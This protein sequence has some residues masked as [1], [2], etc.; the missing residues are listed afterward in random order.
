MSGTVLAQAIT[1]GLSFALARLYAPAEFGHYSIFV[2]LAGMLGA[3]STGA[4][5]RVILMVPSEVEARRTATTVLSSAVCLA[6]IVSLIGA[7]LAGV[8]ATDVLPLT[9]VDLT[10]LIPVFMVCF[11]G[12]QVFNYSSLRT[13]R[14][15][16]LAALKV[17]QSLTMGAMQVLA[18]G[19]K[20]VP[21]LILGNIAGWAILLASGL[22]WRFSL[23]H[24]RQ[25]LTYRSMA[26]VVRRHWRYPRYVMPNEALDRLS[27]QVPLLFIG[28]FLSLAA[29]GHYGFALMILSGPAALMGQAVGQAFLQFM[30]RHDNNALSL[31][32]A[33]RRIWAGMALVGALPFGAVL[34]FGGEIF[35]TGFGEEWTG[36]GTIAQLL[37]VLLFVRFVS[38]PTSTLYWKLNLQREQWY[39]S[40]AAASYRTGAYG[41]LAFGFSLREV[42]FLHVGIETVA[43][44]TYN[45]VAVRELW[46]RQREQHVVIA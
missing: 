10:V 46:R 23:G 6:A 28:T 32:L 19:A 33:T 9:A 29:A 27:N 31:D 5:D 34:L 2:G 37:A 35:G 26:A 41:L 18:S 16:R 15:R 21:G 17:C 38:S 30:G 4:L 24:F 36:A 43:I 12:A 14:V 1:L 3:V 22:R 39:F 8:G 11:A 13:G 7:V 25:D 40:V 45:L 20:S 42:I 44:V